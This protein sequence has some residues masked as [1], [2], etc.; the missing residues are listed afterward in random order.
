MKAFKNTLFERVPG[1][2]RPGSIRAKLAFKK[3]I[4]I[5]FYR[6]LIAQTSNDVQILEAL[7]TYRPR[8][9]RKKLRDT[10][11]VIDAVI[12]SMQ[13]GF[14][15]DAAL[16]PWVPDTE[17]GVLVSGVAANALAEAL[18]QLLAT[19]ARAKAIVTQIRVSFSIPIGNL[20]IAFA[21]MYFIGKSILPMFETLVPRSRADSLVKGLYDLGTYAIGWGLPATVLGIVAIIALIV[22]SLPR[23]T[24]PS[25]LVAEKVF[26]WSYYRDMQ[27]FLWLTN[28]ASL[29]ASGTKELSALGTQLTAAS[30]WLAERLRA[31]RSKMQGGL[32]LPAALKS[33]APE[34][35][36]GLFKLKMRQTFEFPNLDMIDDIE[37]L[38]GFANFPDRIQKSADQW[39]VEIAEKTA[40]MTKVMGFFA[41]L[42]TYGLIIYIIYASNDLQLAL[43]SMTNGMPH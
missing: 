12:T 42:L 34:D 33:A 14:T 15:L 9:E 20:A 8:L 10:V 41:N 37:S 30:P 22:W 28:Y 21:F 38:H 5:A 19:E 17:Y 26:P 18:T 7:K 27:G 25:R 23:W 16:R 32:L 4:R 31:I 1:R 3:S 36:T 29:L 2:L 13:N 6:H 39:A 43:S 35:D 24:G 11:R 40:V